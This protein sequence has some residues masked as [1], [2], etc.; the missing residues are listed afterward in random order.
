[1]S[2]RVC[3]RDCFN[4]KYKD[5]IVSMQSITEDER[6]SIN[7]RD[8][9]GKDILDPTL[10][11][12]RA[13]GRRYYHRHKN[14]QS[15]IDYRKKYNEEHREEKRADSKRRHEENRKEDNERVL[16]NY[17]AKHEENKAKARERRKSYY[18]SNIEESRR[19]QREYR[20]RRK[21]QLLNA[22]IKEQQAVGI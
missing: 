18:H 10:E 17:Y 19:K 8:N 14:E 13:N 5:C 20:A 22:N 15:H 7:K 12:K 2:R 4:C 3:G 11:R 6:K 16:A 9:E 21:E 1:M